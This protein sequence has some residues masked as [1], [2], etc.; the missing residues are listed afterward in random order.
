MKS[1]IAVAV[2]ALFL[3]ACFG[4]DDPVDPELGLC[5]LEEATPITV[6]QTINGTIVSTDCQLNAVD[7]RRA[8]LYRFV[9]ASGQSLRITHSSTAF[10]PVFNVYNAT[11][12]VLIRGDTTQAAASQSLVLD[13]LTPATYYVAATTRNTSASGAYT[14]EV[15]NATSAATAPAIRP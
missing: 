8:D 3:A 9:I 6:P 5:F 13:Q 4:R 2:V 14:L 10:T 11:G 7:A 1:Q 15:V 12:G